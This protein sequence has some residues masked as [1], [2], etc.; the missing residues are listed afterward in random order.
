MHIG[1]VALRVT[2]PETSARHLTDTLGLRRTLERPELLTLSCNEKHHEV[3]LIGAA[4]AGLD[5]IGLEVEHVDHLDVLRDALIAA[6]APILSEAPQ[7]PG[8]EHALRCLGPSDVVYE[9]YAG[10]EREPLSVEHY[11]PPLARRFGHVNIASSDYLETRRFLTDVLR[12]R[13]TDVLGENVTWLRC[14]RDHHG[15]AL[16]KAAANTLHHYAFEVENWGA[17]ERYCDHLALLGKRLI[18]GPG[19]HGPGRNL[20]TYTTDPEDAVV[21][22]Y[23]DLLTI[24]DEANYAPIDW[25]ER[26][27]A[28]LNLWGPLPPSDYRDHGVPILAP[29]TAA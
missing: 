14:D 4:R 13:V 2:D 22:A 3:E 10:M 6:G 9:I 11:M 5:H 26:G 7:E 23:A 8:L 25:S 15:I 1:H 17:L 16:R 24:S 19:R 18:W 27:D 29:D 28:A 20:Y 21:E 12:F